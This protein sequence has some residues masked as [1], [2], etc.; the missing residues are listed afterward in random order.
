MSPRPHVRAHHRHPRFTHPPL[1]TDAPALADALPAAGRN[2]GA[3]AL[4]ASIA[5]VLTQ[6]ADVIRTRLQLGGM[7]PGTRAWQAGTVLVRGLLAVAAAEGPRAL[8]VGGIARIAKRALSTAL[9]WTLFEEGMAW[10]Q[11]RGGTEGQRK[12]DGS[13]GV[14]G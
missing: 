12:R 10:G 13:P 2:F 7:P 11:R 6:P 1:S 4:A 14:G 9:T 3:A 5:T 8:F